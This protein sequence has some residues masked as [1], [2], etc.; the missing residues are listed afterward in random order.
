MKNNHRKGQNSQKC[1]RLILC[2]LCFFVATSLSAQKNFSLIKG[3]VVMSDGH[4]LAGAKVTITRTDAEP[5]QQKKSRK[6]SSRDQ[7]GELAFRMDVGRAKFH[8]MGETRKFGKQEKNQPFRDG[9]PCEMR[10]H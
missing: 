10:I 8:L 4:P 1:S 9:R 7:Q 3:T 2:L 5:K 6:E